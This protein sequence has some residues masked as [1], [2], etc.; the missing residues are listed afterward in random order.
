MKGQLAVHTLGEG[1]SQREPVKLTVGILEQ[2]KL[3]P[4]TSSLS[5]T[6]TGSFPDIVQATMA[7]IG[8]LQAHGREHIE[9]HLT[10]CE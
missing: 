8:Q 4:K 5:T 10:L 3:A 6:V 7:T 1:P 9:V 2:A